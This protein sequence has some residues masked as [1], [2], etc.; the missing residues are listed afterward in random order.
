MRGWDE[1]LEA[2]GLVEVLVR[3]WWARREEIAGPREESS[4]E[5][6]C[7]CGC[8][9]DLFGKE[10][11]V[12]DMDG[13]GGEELGVISRRGADVDGALSVFEELFSASFDMGLKV[14]S[15]RYTGWSSA[16]ANIS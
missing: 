7:G 15:S 13:L 9:F 10:P 3:W 5:F 4:I 8:G 14:S 16:W 1:E 2:G 12:G 11:L 6:L